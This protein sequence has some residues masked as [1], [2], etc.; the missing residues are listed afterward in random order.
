MAMKRRE[1]VVSRIRIFGSGIRKNGDGI[2][3]SS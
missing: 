2:R 1:N 3:V